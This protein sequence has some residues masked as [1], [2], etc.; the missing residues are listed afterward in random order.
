M[1]C[2]AFDFDS[3]AHK[4]DSTWSAET[5]SKLAALVAMYG[6]YA[7][8]TRSGWRWVVALS[9][10][11]E[12][13]T[14]QDWDAWRA[15]YLR[16]CDW[17]QAEHGLTADRSCSEPGRLFRLPHVVRDGVRLE[18]VILGS[19]EEL[20]AF[21][22]PEA[23]SSTLALHPPAIQAVRPEDAEL[24]SL[25]DVRDVP[26]ELDASPLYRRLRDSGALGSPIPGGLAYRMRCPRGAEHTGS[27]GLDGSTLFFPP[28]GAGSYGHIHCHHAGCAELD[29]DELVLSAADTAFTRHEVQIVSASIERT[30]SSCR[31][32]CKLQQPAPARYVRV[33]NT[34]KA[35]WR[36]LWTGADVAPPED[37]EGDLTEAC[38]ELTGC[39]IIVECEG[40]VVRRI[41]PREQ[42]A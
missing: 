36:A 25:V 9:T 15:R 35:R 19:V 28:G 33:A 24:G 38:R 8:S 41:L 4:P 40:S 39:R 18:P 21:E 32:V 1:T 42:A 30:M 31:V 22:L 17:L 29:L 5:Q 7:Y 16:A 12:L 34:T 20:G 11:V 6:G 27:D 26:P 23:T 37:L 2:V 13:H 10:I 3:P 14:A